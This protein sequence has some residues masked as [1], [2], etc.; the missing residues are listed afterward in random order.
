MRQHAKMEADQ[1]SISFY[2]RTRRFQKTKLVPHE[3]VAQIDLI[4]LVHAA[5]RLAI[6]SS[7]L[8]ASRRW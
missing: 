5:L 6:D 1:K 7:S 8:G 2:M 3:T 4:Y